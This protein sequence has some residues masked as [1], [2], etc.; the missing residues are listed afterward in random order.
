MTEK[1]DPVE[2]R[3]EHM[4]ELGFTNEE[5]MVLTYSKDDKGVFL[6]YGD[7]EKM[8]KHAYEKIDDARKAKQLVYRILVGLDG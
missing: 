6:H 2:W 5:A 1:P 3:Y 7:V 4:Q 8:L